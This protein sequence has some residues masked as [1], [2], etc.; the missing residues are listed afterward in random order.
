MILHE[1]HDECDRELPSDVSGTLEAG[2][3][4]RGPPPPRTAR[5]MQATLR[6]PS[7]AAAPGP[8]ARRPTEL[9]DREAPGHLFGD[10]S[11]YPRHDQ[12]SLGKPSALPPSDHALHQVGHAQ[13][14][15]KSRA[16]LADRQRA[17]QACAGRNAALP[18]RRVR[19]AGQPRWSQ[20]ARNAPS[21][22]LPRCPPSQTWSAAPCLDRARTFKPFRLRDLDDPH[23]CK[24]SRGFG[25]LEQMRLEGHHQGGDAA[26]QPGYAVAKAVAAS[27]RHSADQCHDLERTARGDPR[28]RGPPGSPHRPPTPAQQALAARCS[29]VI[30]P[31]R[32]RDHEGADRRPPRCCERSGRWQ[33][34]AA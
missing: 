30:R 17:L 20:A 16:R 11:R 33:A 27:S 14:Y 12:R 9:A 19:A 31:A 18:L 29:G 15:V 28:S 4:V 32:L 10:R 1:D 3:D 21:A 26:Q 6:H 34:R 22:A 7:G 2:L 23:Q 5:L 8:P 25:R 24:C 13:L